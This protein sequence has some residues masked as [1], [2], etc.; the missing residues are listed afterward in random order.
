MLS[1]S[2]LSLLSGFTNC[3]FIHA[4]TETSFRCVTYMWLNERAVGILHT[5]T[6]PSAYLTA[7]EMNGKIY[8]L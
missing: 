6:Q 7:T 2:T 8:A 4:E 3:T 5:H 1:L